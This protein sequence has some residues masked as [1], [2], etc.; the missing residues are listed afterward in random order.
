MKLLQSRPDVGKNI[1]ISLNI[2][3]IDQLFV[4]ITVSY[5]IS[6]STENWY[7]NGVRKKN[8]YNTLMNLDAEGRLCSG[9][10]VRTSMIV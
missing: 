6:Y 1:Y 5:E 8:Y 9:F 7:I 2:E 4:D 10:S 3:L